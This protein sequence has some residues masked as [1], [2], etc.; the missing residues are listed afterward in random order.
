[1]N[2]KNYA[3]QFI[4]TAGVVYFMGT[5][6]TAAMVQFASVSVLSSVIADLAMPMIDKEYAALN[7]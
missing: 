5:T 6:D 3:I 2:F 7:A 1:M 4:V